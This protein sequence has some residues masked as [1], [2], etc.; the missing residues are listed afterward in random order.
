MPVQVVSLF[1]P[2]NVSFESHVLGTGEN[3]PLQTCT[4]I[5]FLQTL[6]HCLI[7]PKKKGEKGKGVK[8]EIRNEKEEEEGDVDVREEKRLYRGSQKKVRDLHRGHIPHFYLYLIYLR[9]SL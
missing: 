2:V 8:M 3:E 9:G 5:M 6:H 1:L 4:C 7:Y